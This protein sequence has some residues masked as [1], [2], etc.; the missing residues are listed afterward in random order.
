MARQERNVTIANPES[1]SEELL[2]ALT[3][4]DEIK[5]VEMPDVS[6][7]EGESADIRGY[8]LSEEAKDM[9]IP[10][11]DDL[12]HLHYGLMMSIHEMGRQYRVLG[13]TVQRWMLYRGLPLWTETEKE[14]L[15][16]LKERVNKR[17]VS[18]ETLD[19]AHADYVEFWDLERE[20]YGY[21]PQECC[22]ERDKAV[23]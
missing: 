13:S 10:S 17:N 8:E 7:T 12:A 2:K 22:R 23:A 4:G 19:K 1:P 5:A 9:A 18:P 11:Y 14:E 20:R 16:K 15:R 3:S 6:T 21:A